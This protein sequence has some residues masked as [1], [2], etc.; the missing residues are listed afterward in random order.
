MV[1]DLFEDLKRHNSDAEEN[2][3]MVYCFKKGKVIFNELLK[4]LLKHNGK[5]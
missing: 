4:S 1:K 3:K 5:I 2:G